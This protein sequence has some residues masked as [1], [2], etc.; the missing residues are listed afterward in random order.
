MGRPVD[1]GATKTNRRWA[2][3]LAG[4]AA[5]GKLNHK[6]RWRGWEQNKLTLLEVTRWNSS[7]SAVHLLE[8]AQR[9][10]RVRVSKK[11]VIDESS[12]DTPT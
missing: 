8:H 12:R 9:I 7:Y 10:L 3:S 4:Q 11:N 2:E 5:L 1:L 6:K